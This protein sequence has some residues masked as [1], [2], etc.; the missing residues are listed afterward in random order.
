MHKTNM[1]DARKLAITTQFHKY[2][3][4]E[5][6]ANEV[7]RFLYPVGGGVHVEAANQHKHSEAPARTS[8][9]RAGQ[10]SDAGTSQ[11]RDI[12]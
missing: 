6:Q 5:G 7:K 10:A 11:A 2:A 1:Q 4:T 12:C 9:N 3:F 8:T